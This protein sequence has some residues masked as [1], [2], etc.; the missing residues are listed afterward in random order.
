MGV[1]SISQANCKNCYK[2]VRSCPVK[3]IKIKAGQAEVVEERCVLCGICLIQCPQ[4][5]KVIRDDLVKVKQLL[6]S[7]HTVAASIAPSYPAAFDVDSPQQFFGLLKR[8]GF[9][10][11]EETSVGAEV[12]SREYARMQQNGS[13]GPIITTACPV[14]KNLIEKYHPKLLN[15]L[16]PLVSPMIAHARMLKQRYGEDT[17]VVFIGPCI[18]KKDE[19]EDVC[20]CGDVDAVLTFEE[21]KAWVE[22]AGIDIKDVEE[23]QQ[24][25]LYPDVARNYPLPGG[26]LKTANIRDDML[27]I[28]VL[29][30]DGINQCIDLLGAIERGEINARFVEALACEGGCIAGP[31]MSSE[32]PVFKRRQQLLK[33]TAKNRRQRSTKRNDCLMEVDLTRGFTAK[34]FRASKPGEK[35]V[36][37]ILRAIGKTSPEKELNCGACGYPSCRDKA[38]AVY[39]GMAELDMCIP[40]MRTK[41]ESLANLI[42]DST[43]NGVILVDGELKIQEL[44][45]AAEKIFG[46]SREQV[47]GKPLRTIMDDVDFVSVLKSHRD[48]VGKKVHYPQY[49][50]TTLQ[51]I[52]YIEEHDLVM[53]IIIDITKQEKQEKELQK[54]REETLN[55]AQ[56]VINK[57]MRVAQEIAGL[58]GETTAESKV[59]LSKLMDL[60]KNGGEKE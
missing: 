10:R 32:E 58:L 2:C 41:A 56:E 7:K 57:Q 22:V 1:M 48:I 5:A 20:V 55:K 51:T 47:K 18:A 14:V 19:A 33:F 60:V 12:L 43:P 13:N 44:N 27:S 54:V 24:D 59:L 53:A 38:V 23:L 42:I 4:D 39:Q 11:V 29:V 35:T 52:C 40:Y 50:L 30:V 15:N 25:G 16:A 9:D 6:D 45:R 8:L 26:L 46:V 49:S 28:D 21:L 17:K 31:V 36:R 34:V 37:E 3:A